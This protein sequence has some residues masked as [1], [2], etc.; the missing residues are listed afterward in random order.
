MTF[1]SVTKIRNKIFSISRYGFCDELQLQ[2]FKAAAIDPG[3]RRYVKKKK[4][5]KELE[6]SF[7]TSTDFTA[8]IVCMWRANV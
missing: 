1:F 8:E 6:T 5:W 2:N 3:L 7:L 4:K